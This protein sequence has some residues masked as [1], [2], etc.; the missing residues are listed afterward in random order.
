MLGRVVSPLV[1]V[2]DVDGIVQ[3]INV[4]DLVERIDFNKLLDSIDLDR[5]FDRV[6]VNKILQ[7]VDVKDLDSDGA[8]IPAIVARSTSGIFSPIVDAYRSQLV[9]VDQAFQITGCKRK[10]RSACSW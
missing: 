6:D 3:R 7:R 5:A 4:N 10:N 8:E 1:D 2:I 9:L